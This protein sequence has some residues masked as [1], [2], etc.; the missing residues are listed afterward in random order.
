M[1]Q[2][3]FHTPVEVGRDVQQLHPSEGFRRKIDLHHPSYYSQDGAREYF[4]ALVNSP[5]Y[6]NRYINGYFQLTNPGQQDFLYEHPNVPLPDASIAVP[7][8]M[9]RYDRPGDERQG[10][11][12]HTAIQN[13]NGW[14]FADVQKK[15]RAWN[16]QDYQEYNS[17]APNYLSLTDFATVGVLGHLHSDTWQ[18]M[19]TNKPFYIPET[20]L[21]KYNMLVSMHKE[22]VSVQQWNAREAYLTMLEIRESQ[23]QSWW[24]RITGSGEEQKR[25]SSWKGTALAAAALFLLVIVIIVVLTKRKGGDGHQTFSPQPAQGVWGY[26]WAESPR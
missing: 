14:Y 18:V 25:P 13:P 1:S 8:N 15:F 6:A 20:T 21:N 5:Q 3:I 24:Q 4:H 10:I 17:S 7:E 9:A 26:D 23:N 16:G 22:A 12:L 2:E 19:D 11:G